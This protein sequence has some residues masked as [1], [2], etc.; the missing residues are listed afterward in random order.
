MMVRSANLLSP[1]VHIFD[2]VINY[3]QCLQY[4]QS[5]ANQSTDPAHGSG[6][7]PRIDVTSHFY[8]FEKHELR[9]SHLLD[10][11]SR[12]WLNLIKTHS[13]WF[14][15]PETIRRQILLIGYHQESLPLLALC[16]QDC[17]SAMEM[18]QVLWIGMSPMP[19]VCEQPT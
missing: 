15:V 4:I 18:N 6:A 5:G 7:K 17:G 16:Q 2:Q 12:H 9:L 8:G 10:N 11:A 19:Y 13:V 3:E 14:Q 1:E